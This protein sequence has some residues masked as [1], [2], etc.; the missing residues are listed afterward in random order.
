MWRLRLQFRQV[1]MLGGE[2]Q[3][4]NRA[5]DRESGETVVS[6]CLL[7]TTSQL[8]GALEARR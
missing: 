4:P 2:F 1:D 7:K 5:L 6:D 3:T 8:Q